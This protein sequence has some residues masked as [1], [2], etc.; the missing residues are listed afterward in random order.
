MI[1]NLVKE[2]I[3][4]HMPT[5]PSPVTSNPVPP[6][7]L[8]SSDLTKKKK[9]KKS[10][11]VDYSESS[12]SESDSSAR[13]KSKRKKS[14]TSPESDSDSDYPTEPPPPSLQK[15]GLLVGQNVSKKNRKKILSGKYVEMYDLLPSSQFKTGRLVINKDLELW[16]PYQKKLLTIS[17]WNQAFA[18]YISIYV[19]KSTTLLECQDLIQQML[20]Y[21]HQI[22]NLYR[23][24][25]DWDT[26]DRMYRADK[27]KVDH[28][29]AT[30]RQDLMLCSQMKDSAPQS[31]RKNKQPFRPRPNLSNY[32]KGFCWKFNTQSEYCDSGKSCRFKHLCPTCQSRHPAYLCPTKS[33]SQ[34]ASQPPIKT[35]ATPFI[36]QPQPPQ[37]ITSNP[38][39]TRKVIPSSG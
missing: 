33:A 19:K 1:S 6:T 8:P 3:Q 27:E 24:G 39:T 18:I 30:I 28:S 14:K 23:D 29:F 4:E 13:H 21:Q 35:P 5:I 26:Y 16:K 25:R 31:F 9:R 15:F 22:N 38:N 34:P 37:N 11:I 20:T 12:E 32:P 10:A 2:A 36:R 7:V 17:E